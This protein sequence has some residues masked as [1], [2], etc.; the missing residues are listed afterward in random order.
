M[1]KSIRELVNSREKLR[2]LEEEYEA[3]RREPGDEEVREP[4]LES[5]K[6]LANQFKEEIARHETN[7]TGSAESE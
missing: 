2:I 5:L 7:T 4:E 1:I 3:A 6:G